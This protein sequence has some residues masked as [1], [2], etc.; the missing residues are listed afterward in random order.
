M[1]NAALTGA[2]AALATRIVFGE[3]GNVNYFGYNISAALANGGTC[4]IGS[5]VSDLTAQ[6]VIKRL[7][8]NDQLMNG[9]I[10]AVETGIC[11]LSS[12]ALFYFG[13]LELQDAPIAFAIGAGSK[14]GG[15]YLNEK[16]FDPRTG[17]LPLF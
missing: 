12:T 3:N 6:Y 1:L 2:V 5:V 4:A 7:G 17:F 16:I 14:L 15:D 10:L 11:G 8:I 9:S 13:G